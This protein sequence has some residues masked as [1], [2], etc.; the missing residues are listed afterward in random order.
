MAAVILL[1]SAMYRA[2]MCGVLQSR[3]ANSPES[4][5]RSHE[6]GVKGAQAENAKVIPDCSHLK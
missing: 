2:V 4:A 1:S 5:K 3:A 6:T